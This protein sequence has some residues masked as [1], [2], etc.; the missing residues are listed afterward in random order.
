VLSNNQSDEIKRCIVEIK[1]I[2]DQLCKYDS[3]NENVDIMA[4]NI[5]RSL[6]RL[7]AVLRILHSEVLI[8]GKKISDV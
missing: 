2:A 8:L 7:T 4:E 3:G 6:N 1:E 5:G